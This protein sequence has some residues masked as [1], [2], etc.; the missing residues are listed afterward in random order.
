MDVMRMLDVKYFLFND[1]Q[2]RQNVQPNDTTMGAAWF[3]QQL[4]P[5]NNPVEEIKALDRV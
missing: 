4:V 1:Q 5:L 3:V 2:G